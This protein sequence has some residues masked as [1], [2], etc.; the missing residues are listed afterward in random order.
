MSELKLKLFVLFLVSLLVMTGL[1]VGGLSKKMIINQKFCEEVSNDFYFVHI[2][3]THILDSSVDNGK[4][5]DNF[6]TLIDHIVSFE[7]KPAFVVI[8]GDL[9]EWGGDCDSGA[10]NFQAFVECLYKNDD[11]LYLDSAF[12]IPVYTTPGNHD[13]RNV[14]LFEVSLFN[15]HNFIDN[16][17]VEENDRYIITFEDLSLFFLNSGHDYFEDP[18]DWVRVLGDGLYDEDIEW[19]EDAL[20]NCVSNHKIVL[21]HH[22]AINDD[23]VKGKMKDVIARNRDVFLALCDEHNVD[24]VLCGHTHVSKILDSDENVYDDSLFN[25]SQ[26]PALHVQT[27]ASKLGRHYRNISIV[28][29]DVW[30]DKCKNVEKTSA[31]HSNDKIFLNSFLMKFLQRIQLTKTMRYMFRYTK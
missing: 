25:C 28:G 22:P 15:Y 18:D 9:V 20:S 2:T 26:Y 5:Q 8:T 24:V 1:S 13:Y 19:L 10:E 14:D 4:R 27:S 12:S 23:Y 31:K 11:Q 3:D 30:L 21:M 16:K 7:K 17:H 29:N 6:Q